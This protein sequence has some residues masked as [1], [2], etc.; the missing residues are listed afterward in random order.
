MP[1]SP[2][3]VALTA[4]NA[5]GQNYPGGRG[6]VKVDNPWASNCRQALSWGMRAARRAGCLAT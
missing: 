3:A 1:P 6:D 5:F 4:V 2:A